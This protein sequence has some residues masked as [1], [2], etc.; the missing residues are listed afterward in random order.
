MHLTIV[1]SMLAWKPLQYIDQAAAVAYLGTVT[2]CGRKNSTVLR[3]NLKRWV[4]IIIGA[5]YKDILIEVLKNAS[6]EA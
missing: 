4:I 6:M 2:S 3:Y 1:A 5:N